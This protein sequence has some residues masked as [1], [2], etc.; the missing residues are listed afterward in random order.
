MTDIKRFPVHT[1]RGPGLRIELTPGSTRRIWRELAKA[2]PGHHIVF[3]YLTQE[4]V[5]RKD[6]SA[7]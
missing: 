3:D 6:E 5:L 4:A 1:Q 2:G 7:Q